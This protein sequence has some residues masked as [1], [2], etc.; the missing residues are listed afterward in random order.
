MRMPVLWDIQYL[1]YH[2]EQEFTCREEDCQIIQPTKTKPDR[3]NGVKISQ[4]ELR[5]VSRLF[6]PISFSFFWISS[7]FFANFNACLS[8][9]STC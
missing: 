7:H 8:V 3:S 5:V 6:F 1:L 9:S 4:R 2:V